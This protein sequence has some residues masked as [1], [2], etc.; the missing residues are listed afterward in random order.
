MLSVN[1]AYSSFNHSR[2]DV[3]PSCWVTA[4]EWTNHRCCWSQD[5]EQSPWQHHFGCFVVSLPQ[6]IK[7]SP[8]STVLPRHCASS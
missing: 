7:D 2:L 4:W 8:V 5:L 3:R 1:V 6:Q